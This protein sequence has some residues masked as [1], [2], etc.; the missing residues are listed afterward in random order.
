MTSSY[1]D[2]TL[3]AI[4]E[5]SDLWKKLDQ[6][7][8]LKSTRYLSLDIF[9]TFFR[10]SCNEP[11]W[12]FEETARRLI[13]Q[14]IPLPMEP[15]DYR[16]CRI[17]AEKCA[18]ELATAEDVTFE[19]I[20]DCVPLSTFLKNALMREELQ[21]EAEILSVDPL[22]RRIIE[23]TL[24]LGKEVIFISDMYL[25]HREIN[26]LITSKY[27]GLVFRKLFVSSDVGLTKL[28]GG[29]FRYVVDTLNTQPECIVR[30]FR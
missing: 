13:K 24:S 7:L 5:N 16:Q 1:F 19:A 11:S 26:A 28:S 21:I 15:L 17:E 6:I 29:M 2:M 9:D 8:G 20:F 4:L 30:E 27:P 22:I 18:R 23:K 10:R 12:V 14:Q 25:S 3:D